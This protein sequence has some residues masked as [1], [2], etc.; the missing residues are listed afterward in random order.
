MPEICKQHETTKQ[1]YYR[2]RQKVVAIQLEMTKKLKTLQND[3]AQ[4]KKKGTALALD[5]KI[6]R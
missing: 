1:T 2:W 4:L 6:L 5:M 3:N